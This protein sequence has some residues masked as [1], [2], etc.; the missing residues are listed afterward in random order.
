[1]SEVT[2]IKTEEQLKE[3][4]NKFVDGVIEKISNNNYKFYIYCPPMNVASGGVS[5]LFRNAQILKE[6]GHNVVIIY[7]PRTDNRASHDASLKAKKRVDIFEPF[8]PTWLGDLAQGIELQCLGEGEAKFSN[9]E[10]KKCMPL[11][12]RK[13]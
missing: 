1:M 5:V 2:Q 11:T 6:A 12:D 9:G 3:E 7:E 13:S 4:H 10:V 8:N